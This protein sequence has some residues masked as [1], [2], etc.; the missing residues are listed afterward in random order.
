MSN[1]IFLNQRDVDYLCKAGAA[2]VGTVIGSITAPIAGPV[3]GIVVGFILGAVCHW[4]I[5]SGVWLDYNIFL[6]Q[7]TNSGWQ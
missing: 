7:V 3:I 4:G 6:R 5:D 2:A 1:K